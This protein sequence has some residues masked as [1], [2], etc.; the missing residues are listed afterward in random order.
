MRL[1]SDSFSGVI[2]RLSEVGRVL[3][4]SSS[5][6]DVSREYVDV[7]TRLSVGEE[8]VARL[9]ALA[10]RTGNLEDML[11]AERELARALTELEGLKGQL[12]YYDQRVAESDLSIALIEP[13]AVVAPSVFRPVADALRDAGENLVRSVA[14]V[15]DAAAFLAPWLVLTA[16]L[17]MALGRRLRT[18]GARRRAATV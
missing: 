4:A 3:S 5:A 2:E 15:I 14:R 17:W 12:R 6:V 9:R 13:G 10:S 8:T 11:A 7:E 18:R 1:P 16:F